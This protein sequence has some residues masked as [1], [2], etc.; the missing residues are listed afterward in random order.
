[1]I[2]L[3]FAKLN[4]FSYF[5]I[6]SRESISY[7]EKASSSPLTDHKS[8]SKTDKK[9]A[10]YSPKK[11]SKVCKTECETYHGL[12][13]AFSSFDEI[14]KQMI[15]VSYHSKSKNNHDYDFNIS[16]YYVDAEYNFE[17]FTW[18]SRQAKD[19]FDTVS[20]YLNCFFT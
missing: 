16:S 14:A 1:M 6:K 17:D 3:I 2:F 4:I 15:E 20:I 12:P 8:S 11:P 7:E 19:W 9:L 13:F 5:W 10:K 18:Y